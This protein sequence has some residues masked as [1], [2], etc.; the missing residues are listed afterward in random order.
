[1]S[2]NTAS[3]KYYCNRKFL[4]W[5]LHIHKVSIPQ[6]VSTIAICCH[7]QGRLL[8]Y[9]VSIPQ[10]VSTI[11]ISNPVVAAATMIQVSIPQAVSTIAIAFGWFVGCIITLSFNTA[12]GK[13]YC[14]ST[15]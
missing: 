7:R 6:A 5:F 15:Y 12:S 13:Y 8:P 10:A 1:M 4:E 9:Q 11:A 14:N 2:F 3:G